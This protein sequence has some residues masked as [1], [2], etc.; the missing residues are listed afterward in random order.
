MK[1]IIFITPVVLS[2]LASCQNS[3]VDNALFENRS[4]IPRDERILPDTRGVVSYENYQV[5]IANG[6]ETVSEIAKR[7]NLDPEKFS[8]FNGLVKSY[9]PRQ[10]ELLALNKYLEPIEKRNTEVWTKKSTKLVLEKA[11]KKPS[12]TRST[13]RFVEHK[14]EAGETIYSIAR[15]YNVAVTSLAKW[16]RLD[17]EFTI[18]IGQKIT[19]PLTL[20]KNN[21][22][23]SLLDTTAKQTQKAPKK[24]KEKNI[25]TVLPLTSKKPTFLQPVKGK[26]V[27]RYN[28]NGLEQKNQGIDIL[29]DPGSEVIAAADGEIALIT[30]S[31][32][33]SG[34]IILMRHQNNLI[35]IYG[36]VTN[37]L[38]KKDQFV[39]KGI[40]I[41][42]S[43]TDKNDKQKKMILHFEIRDGTKSVNPE[44]YF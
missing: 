20:K 13:N 19:V 12:T 25:D 24:I 38:V 21:S 33:S 34:K 37:I 32:A 16:N 30:D 10:G 1:R 11:K 6:N 31:T 17:A 28:P 9:R 8:L 4:Q 7:L 39:K 15:L 41:G 22:K 44:D 29:T 26:I 14:V 43:M 23:V 5:V 36:R 2:I 18:Y 3:S 40:K 35:S 27:N 42:S